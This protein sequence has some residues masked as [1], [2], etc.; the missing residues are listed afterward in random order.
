MIEQY[1]YIDSITH[2]VTIKVKKVCVIAWKS[3]MD[4]K[5]NEKYEYLN[6]YMLNII[7]MRTIYTNGREMFSDWFPCLKTHDITT[8]AYL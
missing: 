4:G 3:S 2:G 7:S 6:F 8:V 1:L 5:H